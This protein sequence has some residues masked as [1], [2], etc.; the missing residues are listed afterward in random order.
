MYVYIMKLFS[1]LRKNEV[2]SFAQKWVQVEN[3][4]KLIK[5]IAKKYYILFFLIV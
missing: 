4:I 2:M 5:I 1:V 3:N